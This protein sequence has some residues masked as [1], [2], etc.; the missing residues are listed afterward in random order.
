MAE[1]PSVLSSLVQLSLP[2]ITLAIAAVDIALSLAGAWSLTRVLQGFLHG[3]ETLH[4][5]TYG[6][7]AG[8]L[9]AVAVLAAYLPARWAASVD[10]VESMRGE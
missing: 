8:L 5:L 6:G 7:I 9:L 1:T 4:P 2:T 3:V 10:P